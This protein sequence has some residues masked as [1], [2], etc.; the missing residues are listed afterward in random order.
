MNVGLYFGSFNPIHVGHCIIANY[1]VQNTPLDQVWLVV[2][3]Q[4]PFK[5]SSKLLNEYQRLH[6]VQLALEGENKLKAS[7][8]EFYL[9]RP[10]YTIDT[11]TYLVEKNPE[12]KFC[13]IM[14]SDGLQNLHKW[15]NAEVLVGTYDIYVYKRPGHEA[16]TPLQARLH[17]MDAPLLEISSTHIRE[18]LRQGKSAR[19]LVPDKVYEELERSRYYR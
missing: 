17:V 11:M 6:L 7:D 15:K 16:S 1:F 3:P 4:N 10:S 9:P 2:S 13:I 12:Y 18:S 14:G 8:V 19:Y 5:P